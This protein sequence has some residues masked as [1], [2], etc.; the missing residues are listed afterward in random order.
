MQ[1]AQLLP[2][3]SPLLLLLRVARQGLPL[4]LSCYQR[5]QQQLM[6]TAR[7]CTLR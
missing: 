4:C 7:L 6:L 2:S 5:Q 3:P 1:E